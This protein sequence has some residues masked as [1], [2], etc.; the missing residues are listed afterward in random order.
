QR[1]AGDISVSIMGL[2]HLGRAAASVLLSLGFAVNGWSRTD[3]PMKGVST[4]AGE[5]GLIPFLNATDIL[6]VLL[7]L[8]PQTQGIVNYGLLKELRRR[9]GLGGAVLINAGRGRLQKDADIVRA[10][11]DGT[12]KEAS[13]DVFEVEPLPK[14]SPLW[15]HPKVFI[16]PHAAATS[17]PAHLVPAMLR[18]MDAFE[19]GEKLENLVDREAGY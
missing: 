16:T 18:Q 1:P 3:R 19:R 2:G 17:D 9:N 5:A 8:T 6:V 12:L 4:Y 10:L 13:L 14:T 15:S 7:P 11:D